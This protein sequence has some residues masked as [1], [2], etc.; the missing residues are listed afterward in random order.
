MPAAIR[1]SNSQALPVWERDMNPEQLEVIRHEQGPI[2]VLAGAG[3][4]KTRALVHRI[5]RLIGHTGVPAQRVCAVTFSTKAATE[6]N[7]RLRA[8]GVED[9]RVGTWHSLCLQI[10]KEDRT[11]WAGWNVD[12]KD[13]HKTI[14]KQALGYQ[15][16]NWKDADLGDVRSYIGI[17]KANLFAPG[18]EDARELARTM[19]AHNAGRAAEAFT[20]SQKLTEER[21]LLTFDDF[22]VFAHQHLSIEENRQRWAGRWDYVLQDEAQDANKAQCEIARLLAKDH[23]N[24]MIVGDT[25]QAIY[26]FRGSTPDYLAEFA[27]EWSAKLVHMDSNYRSGKAIVK[28]AN[29][30]I[31]LA[32]TY[33]PTD[34][35]AMRDVEGSVKVAASPDLDGEAHNFVGWTQDIVA[36]GGKYSDV[37]CLFRTN[38][39]SRALEEALLSAKIPYVIV[40]GTSFYERKEVKDLLAYL[41]VAADLDDDGDALRRCINA[42]FRYLGT[43]FVERV[44]RRADSRGGRS[45]AELV[46]A[47]SQEAGIQRRQQASV[48]EWAG[49]VEEV[50]RVISSDAAEEARPESLLTWVV[51]R[52]RYIEWLT[53]DEGEESISTSH[54]ANVRELIRVA[55]RFDTVQ[56]LLAYIKQS[57]ESARRQRSDKQ[58]GGERVLL[59]SIHR[60]KGLEW[61][62]LWVAGCNEKVLPH[63]YGDIEEERRLAYVAATRARDNLVLSYVRSFATGEGI[64]DAHPSRFLVE[65]GLIQPATLGVQGP[66]LVPAPVEA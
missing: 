57:I 54:G 17:C 16:L 34:M 60:S 44:S 14:V 35:I 64:K 65:V 39:Q 50:A 23:R 13:S 66:A 3:S 56:E 59:M 37:T 19:F 45:W 25:R 21:G 43:A 8:L 28:V 49:I 31:R 36:H 22:L 2:A 46:R 62:N 27:E 12:D 32:T 63:A 26:S 24:Y 40:G 41:R 61:P 6:M 47:V 48:E 33:T 1:K 5:A 58:S 55:G 10:L 11:E 9:A 52:T 20:I 51:N 53:R 4:G 15:F 7:E 42:P 29:E 18:G 38:A 30:I